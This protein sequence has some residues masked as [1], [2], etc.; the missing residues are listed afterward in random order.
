MLVFFL[1]NLTNGSNWIKERW[2]LGIVAMKMCKIP[3][4]GKKGA[5]DFG[6]PVKVEDNI[7]VVVSACVTG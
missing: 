4:M 3:S 2:R 7:C 1:K 6:G 5:Q